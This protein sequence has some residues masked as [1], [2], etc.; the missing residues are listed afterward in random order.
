MTGDNDKLYE[1]ICS[2]E[3][4]IEKLTIQFL[5][6]RDNALAKHNNERKVWLDFCFLFLVFL[7]GLKFSS[8]RCL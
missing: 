2:N 5:K 4:L 3:G 8:I 7:E 6:R 1:I